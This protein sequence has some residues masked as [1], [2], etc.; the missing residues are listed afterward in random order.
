MNLDRILP[1]T[2][3]ALSVAALAWSLDTAL[4]APRRRALL[5]RKAEAIRSL[6]RLAGRHAAERAWLE[7]LDSSADAPPG[8][9]DAL[10]A[11]FFPDAA[12]SAV[13]GAPLPAAA[14]WQCRETRLSLSGV[15]YADLADF[16]AEAARQRPPWRLRELDLHPAETT[17]TGDAD[18]LFEVLEK[19]GD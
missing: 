3:L 10:A 17:G 13:P 12:P 16:C 4:S 5:D 18:L 1:G 7:A 11:R 15:S 19:S 9:L 6:Q 8:S 14:G 2:A